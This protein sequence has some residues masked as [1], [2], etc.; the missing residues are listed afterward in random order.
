MEVE[1]A[2]K[3]TT[4]CATHFSGG[5]ATCANHRAEGRLSSGEQCF[6]TV[7]LRATLFSSRYNAQA[8]IKRSDISAGLNLGG[9]YLTHLAQTLAWLAREKTVVQ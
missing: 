8:S 2:L 6:A 5:S 1:L 3:K 9:T 7:L 4:A